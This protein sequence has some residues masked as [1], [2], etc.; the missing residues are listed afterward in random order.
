MAVGGPGPCQGAAL[1]VTRAS[2]LT[3]YSTTTWG[4]KDGLLSAVVWAVAQDRD[5]YLWLATD[6]GL[7][8]FDGMRFAPADSLGLSVPQG[9]VRAALV[10]TDGVIWIGFGGLGG[11][12][13]IERRQVRTYGHADGLPPGVITLLVEGPGNRVWVGNRQ[14]LFT[15]SGERWTRVEDGLPHGPA[16]A[17]YHNRSGD[18]FVSTDAGIF[19]RGAGRASFVRVAPFDGLVRNIVEDSTGTLW[20]SD[21]V[22][23]ARRLNEPKRGSNS[24]EQGR[25]QRLLHDSRGNLWIG[26][27]G[28]G[29]WRVRLDSDRRFQRLEKAN[30]GTGLSNEA[31]QG[32]L[33]DRDGNIWVGTFDGLNRL[34]PHKATQIT[35]LGIVSGV[36]ITAD[37]DVWV[38]TIDALVRFPEG[39]VDAHDAP[40]R[41]GGAT[42]SATHA[43]GKG[44]LWVA[45]SHGLLQIVRGRPVRVRLP[46]PPLR[47]I[48][49]MTSDRHGRLWLYDVEQGLFRLKA[50]RIDPMVL[51]PKAQQARIVAIHADSH[52]RV[53]LSFDNGWIG[54]VGHDEQVQLH[55]PADGLDAG[56]YRTFH[57]G[58]DGTL[59]LGGTRG[60]SRFE[61]GRFASLPRRGR[62]PSESITAIFDDDSGQV[63]LGLENFGIA[64][65]SR[66]EL[67]AAFTTA[68]HQ[69]RFAYYDR[70]DGVAGTPQWFG[71]RSGVRARDGRLWFV[72]G[73]GLTVMDPAAAEAP[74]IRTPVSIEAI[75]ADG[76]RIDFLAG[77]VL[78]PRTARLDIEYSALNLTSPL[79]TRFRY[80]LE[81]FDASWIDAGSRRQA[82]Y[83]NLPPR[84]YRFRVVSSNDEGTWIDTG[85]AWSFSIQP[86]FYQT[87]WFYAA[88]VALAGLV[89]AGAWRFH[90]RQVRTNFALLL[91]ERTRLSR[92]IHDTL[93][94]GMVGVALQFDVLATDDESPA[95]ERRDQ[96][97]RMRKNIEEY[98]RE[99]RQ[100]IWDLRSQ[101]LQRQDLA[102]ALRQTGEQATADTPAQFAF[103]LRGE[104]HRCSAR[105]EEQLLR[106]GQEAVSNAVRHARATRIGIEL[107][108][109]ARRIILRVVD[110][111][112]GF[113]ADPIADQPHG[114]YGL[115]S[116]KERAEDV[117]G[118]L[119]VITGAGEG[120]IVE[121]IVPARP[122]S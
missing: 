32:L 85:A 75:V 35:N 37:G 18:F 57:E 20:L 115:V 65:L 79:K 47:R 111:G 64:R 110:D 99:A 90:L 69:L 119:K 116:M 117:G 107:Q 104:P 19:R 95:A 74:E 78:P 24:I 92:E 45:T 113:V 109:D 63:W 62:F 52:D 6:A 7:V 55:G 27:G 15:R 53:W 84:A 36:E 102:S 17:A 10:T 59:W 22:A 82:F 112:V 8:R 121:A 38:R 23:G 26:T 56:P 14:G 44:S 30:T 96:L 103:S 73:R 106:I 70:S 93:L 54:M 39:R 68:D 1:T 29:L 66:E 49:A 114:H 91:G 11:V 3:G 2:V 118:T 86:T 13:R 31:I 34:T 80:Q 46:G 58:R 33:E 101:R 94:Q 25:G 81:G 41:L 28:Q 122:L 51:P 4:R 67:N 71:T 89:I 97:V 98:V 48:A 76:Q 9:P 42:L 21:L 88:S 105:V 100:S 5:G 40:V 50:G 83:T 16:H 61:H 108:F 120:T 87:P 77:S 60:L 72:S 12:A 43:D